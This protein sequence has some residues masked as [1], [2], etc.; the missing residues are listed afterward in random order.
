MIEIGAADGRED[1]ASPGSLSS[2]P[3]RLAAISPRARPLHA[4]VGALPLL[5][6]ER[7]DLA[8]LDGCPFVAAHRRGQPTTRRLDAAYYDTP[9]HALRR[10]DLALRVRRSGKRFV[11]TLTRAPSDGHPLQRCEWEVGIVWW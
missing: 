9:D 1:D 11:Q 10:A 6:L 8:A 3:I 2:Q 7:K 4:V 5:L